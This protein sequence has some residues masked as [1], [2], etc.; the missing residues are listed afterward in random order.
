MI[1]PNSL[2]RPTSDDAIVVVPSEGSKEAGDLG[3]PSVPAD[4]KG[5]ARDDE[6]SAQELRTGGK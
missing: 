2:L 6:Q 4:G 3:G 1:P 5:G